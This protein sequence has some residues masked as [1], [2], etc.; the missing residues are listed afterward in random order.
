ME[1][2]LLTPFGVVKEQHAIDHQRTGNAALRQQPLGGDHPNGPHVSP[3]PLKGFYL[4]MMGG[5]LLRGTW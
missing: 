3:Q 4:W 2:F 5:A 1:T